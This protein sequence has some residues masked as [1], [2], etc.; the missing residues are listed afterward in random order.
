LHRIEVL[1][2]KIRWCSS[3]AF[4]M[5]SPSPMVRLMGFSHKTSLPALAA[6]TAM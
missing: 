6:A 2:R 3:T 4:T 5:A 1:M